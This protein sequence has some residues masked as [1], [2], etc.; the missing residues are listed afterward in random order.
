MKRIF[1]WMPTE[2]KKKIIT[3]NRKK[4]NCNIFY[5]WETRTSNSWCC[6]SW[7]PVKRRHLGCEN[8]QPAFGCEHFPAW[9]KRC[10]R[11]AG[12]WCAI[13]WEHPGS[14]AHWRITFRSF[15]LHHW[16]EWVKNSPAFQLTV[17][18]SKETTQF[19]SEFIQDS[20][21]R[22]RKR[23]SFQTIHGFFL[24]DWSS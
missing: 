10:K 8:A 3:K 17:S 23:E 1:I 24:E 4:L 21:W 9:R 7:R 11:G 14:W 19:S 12:V 2:I 15:E 22:S 20:V 16:L 13:Q 18:R 5:F 6:E